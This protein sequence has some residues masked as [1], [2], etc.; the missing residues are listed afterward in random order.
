MFGRRQ[1]R[2]T[3]VLLPGKSHGPRR[4]QSMGSLRVGHDWATSLSLF[5]LMHWRKKW[6]STPVFLPGESQGREPGGLPFMGSHRVRHDW[7][8]LAAAVKMFTSWGKKTCICGNVSLIL[9]WTFSLILTS[10]KSVWVLKLLP[11]RQQ[12]RQLSL[13]ACVWTCLKLL[14]L[15]VSQ[16]NLCELSA[17]FVTVNY[18][19]KNLKR[20]SL[21]YDIKTK[22]KVQKRMT[23]DK[24]L[25]LYQLKRLLPVKYK[26]KILSE[27][28]KTNHQIIVSLPAFFLSWCIKCLSSEYC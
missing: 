10:V 18:W 3:P 22:R 28:K 6:Q 16:L 24:N 21:W 5:T 2:P 17:V 7:R 27:K 23:Y 12:S 20:I 25:C 1:W 13:S 26:M 9:N 4:L 14:M 8:D 19:V 11:A 15:L